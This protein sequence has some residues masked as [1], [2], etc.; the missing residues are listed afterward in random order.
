MAG[1]MPRLL[2]GMRALCVLA[3]VFFNFAHA[4][5]AAGA[6]PGTG[7][8]CGMPMDVPSGEGEPGC[9]PCLGAAGFVL[10]PLP[11]VPPPL[12]QQ[13]APLPIAREGGRAPLRH[14]GAQPRAPPRA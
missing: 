13:E 2:E 8:I 14:A 3:L 9:T 10:P 5:V 12:L 11:V 7:S 4:P 1:L 6:A